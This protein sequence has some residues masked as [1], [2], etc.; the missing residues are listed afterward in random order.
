M[1]YNRNM[2]NVEYDQTLRLPPNAYQLKTD[3]WAGGGYGNGLGLTYDTAHEATLANRIGGIG[4]TSLTPNSFKW[5]LTHSYS[6]SYARRIPLNQ[7]VEVSYVGTRGRDLVSRSNG[8]VMPF[9]VLNSGTFKGI[10]LSNPVNRVAV[11]SDSGNLT[12]FRNFNAL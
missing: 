6:V 1:F 3:F 11:A 8:N 4:I 5:P 12:T 10:D 2:G 9:G 7:V